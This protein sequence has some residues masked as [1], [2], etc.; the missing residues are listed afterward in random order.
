MPDRFYIGET[1]H[2]STYV[3]DRKATRPGS[4]VVVI[5]DDDAA[6][7]CAALNAYK[8]PPPVEETD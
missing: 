5:D 4:F 2:S 3:I 7:V 1:R 6:W 8:V